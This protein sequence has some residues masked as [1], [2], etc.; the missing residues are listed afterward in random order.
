MGVGTF[1]VDYHKLLDHYPHER[2]SAT[3]KGEQISNGGAPLNTLVNLARLGVD[4]PLH[5][6]AKVGKDLD[7]KLVLECCSKHHINVDQILVVEGASTGYTDVFTVE[8]SGQHTC[9]HYNGIGDT[10]DRDNVK[11]LAANPKILFFGSLGA[12]GKLDQHNTKFGRRGATQLLRDARKNK[13]ITV[14]EMAPTEQHPNLSQFKESLAE[15]DYLVINDHL[16]EKLTGLSLYEDGE[17][18]PE[19]AAK[20]AAVLMAQ[21][22]RRGVAIRTSMTAVFLSS[23]GSFVHKKGYLLPSSQRVGSAGLDHAFCAGFLEGLYH[24]KPMPECLHQ[25]LAVVASC[26]RDLTPSDGIPKLQDCLE[27][28]AS[29]SD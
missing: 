23:D 24:D 2:S 11:L 5:A 12:L 16:I 13:I 19:L 26:R 8:S 7:G 28:Y 25:G 4:F 14:V 17:F 20:A 9:F 18:D 1:V 3:V 15:T 21:G 27:F 6:G 22:I 10:Y 29:L